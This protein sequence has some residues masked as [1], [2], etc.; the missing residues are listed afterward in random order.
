[1]RSELHASCPGPLVGAPLVHAWSFDVF[2]FCVEIEAILAHSRWHFRFLAF[3][4]ISDDFELFISCQCPC[5]LAAID[6]A[7]FFLVLEGCEY[8]VAIVA[9]AF[10][11]VVEAF[12][13]LD[14]FELLVTCPK[15]AVDAVLYPAW[16]IVVFQGFKQVEAFIAKSWWR[17]FSAACDLVFCGPGPCSFA[18]F[19][20]AWHGFWFDGVHC[21]P[22]F[23][24]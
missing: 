7:F 20:S 14:M 13:R 17:L 12:S 3:R 24:A 4:R 9:H 19:E 6:L 11:R 21:L 10:W 8:F 16:D 22:A 18:S 5:A 23:W 2:G 1:M 15:D